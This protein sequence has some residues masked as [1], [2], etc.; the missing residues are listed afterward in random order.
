MG[1][2][3]PLQDTGFFAARITFYY[4]K[5]KTVIKNEL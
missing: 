2:T 4:S 3:A 1:V 5:S